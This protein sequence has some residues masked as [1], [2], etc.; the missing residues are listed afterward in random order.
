MIKFT[1]FWILIYEMRP[2]RFI[3]YC[4]QMREAI[5]YLMTLGY[6]KVLMLMYKSLVETRSWDHLIL[7]ALRDNIATRDHAEAKSELQEKVEEAPT[8]DES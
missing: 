7:K 4:V 2:S 6:R 8:M 5:L 1:F 3:I